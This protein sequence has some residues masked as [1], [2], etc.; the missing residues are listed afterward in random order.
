MESNVNVQENLAEINEKSYAIKPAIKFTDDNN[1]EFRLMSEEDEKFM[2]TTLDSV[3]N[4]LANNDISTLSDEDAAPKI[5]EVKD[6][7]RGVGGRDGRLSKTKFQ[8]PLRR[9]EYMMMSDLILKHMEYDVDTLFYAIELRQALSLMAT[10]SEAV[11][12]KDSKEVITWDFTALDLTYL[13]HVL[14]KHKVKGLQKQ[15]YTFAEILMS[16][17]KTSKVF[18]YY[19][20]EVENVMKMIQEWMVVPEATTEA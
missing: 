7:W 9:E 19:K 10:K 15:A 18:D 16:I 1:V 6:M 11:K 13:Y 5:A 8:L 20:S 14:S 3:V 2:D 17:A 4:Y 12:Y